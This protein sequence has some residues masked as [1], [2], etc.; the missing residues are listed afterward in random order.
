MPRNVEIKASV[1]DPAALLK[2]AGELSGESDGGLKIEQ[3]DTF[4]NAANGRLKL[5]RLKT[6]VSNRS[7]E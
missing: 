4:F 6:Y 5:R 1:A 3:R 2:R 7:C